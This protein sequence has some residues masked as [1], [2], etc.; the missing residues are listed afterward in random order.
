MNRVFF[1]QYGDGGV[2]AGGPQE[3]DGLGKIA[4]GPIAFLNNDMAQEMAQELGGNVL[5]RSIA[6]AI[7]WCKQKG[8]TL[9]I[10]FDN[11]RTGYHPATVTPAKD[12]PGLERVEGDL[13]AKAIEIAARQKQERAIEPLDCEPAPEWWVKIS[14]SD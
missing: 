2:Y 6:H 10:R 14:Q 9:Y 8:M 4:G 7:H 13:R 1:V 5:T 3:L 12:A 11:G